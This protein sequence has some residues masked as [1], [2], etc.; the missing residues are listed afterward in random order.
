M[1]RKLTALALLS[2]LI[3]AACGDSTNG[4]DTDTAPSPNEADEGNETPGT[5]APAEPQ[6]GCGAEGELGIKDT[7]EGSGDDAKKGNVLRVNYTGTLEDGTQFDSS[8]DPGRSP[9]EFQLGAGQVIAGWDEGYGGMKEGGRRTLTIPWNLGYGEAG[10]PPTIPP[11]ATLIFDVEL[12][13]IL[14]K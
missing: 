7:K 10:A 14:Q 5:E 9:F 1:T 2:L 12:V 4:T 6:S 8:L 11:C 13:K 3:F